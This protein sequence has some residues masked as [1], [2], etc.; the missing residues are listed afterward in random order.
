MRGSHNIVTSFSSPLVVIE[1]PIVTILAGFLASLGQMNLLICYPLVVVADIVGDM[2]MYAQGRWGGKPAVERW[3]H[4]FG[5]KPEMIV[6]LEERFKKHPGK[7]LIL[8]KVSHFFGGPILIAAGMARMRISKFLW[9]NFIGT[10]P[11]SLILLLLGF[12]FGQAYEKF[13]RVFTY[14]GWAA[15]ALV[16]ISVVIYIAI[17]KKSKKY[18]EKN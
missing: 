2:S 6:R 4:R 14:A 8:G 18:I 1:G 15:V 7:T 17:A 11:K 9:Y 3:G 5:I 13:D 16:V 10:V 12:Y